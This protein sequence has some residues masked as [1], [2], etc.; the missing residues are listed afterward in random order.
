[1]RRGGCP[2]RTGGS[3]VLH[4]VQPPAVTPTRVLLFCDTLTRHVFASTTRR[5]I[6]GRTK[7]L[8][9]GLSFSFRW[10]TRGGSRQRE[11]RQKSAAVKRCSSDPGCLCAFVCRFLRHGRK[12]RRFAARL[13]RKWFGRGL[14]GAG[15]SAAPMAMVLS[16]DRWPP[17][18]VCGRQR[19]S[20]RHMQMMRSA[21]SADWLC[22]RSIAGR[23]GVRQRALK[24][25][26]TE[27]EQP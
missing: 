13:R 22:R 14:L 10:V 21:A 11:A 16:A 17:R 20:A 18:D 6:G 4:P 2:Y 27:R 25:H 7:C 8:S 23:G 24:D 9:W 15:Y 26:P 19:K 12:N 1:M 3:D 5:L